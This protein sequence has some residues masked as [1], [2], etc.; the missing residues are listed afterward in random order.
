MVSLVLSDPPELSAITLHKG[1]HSSSLSPSI[2]HLVLPIL[3]VAAQVLDLFNLTADG[4]MATFQLLQPALDHVGVAN[5]L[6]VEHAVC[7]C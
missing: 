7:A 4:T 1:Q 3:N 2:I 5:A 6:Q